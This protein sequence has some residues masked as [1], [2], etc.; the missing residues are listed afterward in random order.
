MGLQ[1]SADLADGSTVL[2]GPYHPA[3]GH[4]VYSEIFLDAACWALKAAHPGGS[5]VA[6]FVNPR[7]I[8]TMRGIK[9]SNIALLKRRFGFDRID[10]V[11]DLSLDEDSLKIGKARPMPCFASGNQ[12]ADL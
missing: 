3:F 9:N 5:E 11:P 12:D 2:A 1:A 4:M 6:I 10:I 8:S 7:R